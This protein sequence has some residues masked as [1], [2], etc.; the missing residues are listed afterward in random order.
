[1]SLSVF[2]PV[3]LTCVLTSLRLRA[4]G[5]SL[6]R[7]RHPTDRGRSLGFHTSQLTYTLYASSSSLSHLDDVRSWLKCKR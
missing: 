7:S 6:A 5:L 4:L 1:M 2:L 3:T